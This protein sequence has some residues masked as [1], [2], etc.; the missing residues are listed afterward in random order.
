MKRRYEA[1]RVS[2]YGNGAANTS[3]GRTWHFFFELSRKRMFARVC[4]YI[5]RHLYR[6]S[7]NRASVGLFIN[8]T[9]PYITGFLLAIVRI[10]KNCLAKC[11]VL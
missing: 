6:V 1:D 5:R 2:L 8:G 3:M 4:T 10:R 9:G 11:F 7:H